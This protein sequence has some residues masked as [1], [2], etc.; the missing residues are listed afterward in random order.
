MEHLLALT[1]LEVNNIYANSSM[2]LFIEGSDQMV[3]MIQRKEAATM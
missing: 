2:D 3:F 1:N